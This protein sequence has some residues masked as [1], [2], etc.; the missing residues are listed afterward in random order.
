MCMLYVYVCVYVCMCVCVY[1]CMCVCVYVCM[2]VCMCVCMYVCMYVYIYIYIYL[3]IIKGR[4]T[5]ED[6]ERMLAEAEQ[7][8]Q[9]NDENPLNKINA[10]HLSNYYYY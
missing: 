4:L 1:V 8:K 7:Q 2:Y 10:M 3:F 5:P 6:I 9:S